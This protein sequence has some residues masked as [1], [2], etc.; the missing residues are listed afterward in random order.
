MAYA[1]AFELPDITT[2]N[3]DTL[4]YTT[5]SV[6]SELTASWPTTTI[7]DNAISHSPWPTG[8]R[9]CTAYRS[10]PT[11]DQSTAYANFSTSAAH[12]V[13]TFAN[14]FT[15]DDTASLRLLSHMLLNFGLT[16]QLVMGRRTT[17]PF[18]ECHFFFCTV[19]AI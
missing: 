10:S 5:G 12:S 19:F 17:V 4:D 13:T 15:S 9:L 6:T 16:L 8:T 7:N 1:S 18:S 14:P 2:Y 3:S 11:L